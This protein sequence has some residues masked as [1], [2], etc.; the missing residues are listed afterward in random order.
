MEKT[1]LFCYNLNKIQVIKYKAGRGI[2][3]KQR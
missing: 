1:W 3:E 2:N